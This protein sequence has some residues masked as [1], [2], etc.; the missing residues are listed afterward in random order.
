MHVR[1]F[2]WC[3]AWKDPGET[4]GSCAWRPWYVATDLT[5]VEDGGGLLELVA[6]NFKLVAEKAFEVVLLASTGHN[7]VIARCAAHAVLAEHGIQQGAHS[8]LDG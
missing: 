1:V 6:V 3:G 7:K 2:A 8:V 4:C 5:L